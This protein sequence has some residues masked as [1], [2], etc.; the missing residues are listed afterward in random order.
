MRKILV[1]AV[2]TLTVAASAAAQDTFTVDLLACDST[3]EVTVPAGSHILLSADWTERNAAAVRRFLRL[4]STSLSVDGN[5]WQT[6]A[7]SGGR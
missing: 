1:C 2:I 7:A 3:G 5:P 4:E 6:R